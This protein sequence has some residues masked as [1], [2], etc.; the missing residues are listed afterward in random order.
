LFHSL[1]TSREY[2]DSSTHFNLGETRDFAP[3]QL[4]ARDNGDKLVSALL[5]S[6][7]FN[8]DHMVH[9]RSFTPSVL[10]YLAHT[11]GFR[12]VSPDQLAA[13]IMLTISLPPATSAAT[14]SFRLAAGSAT[15]SR[16]SPKVSSAR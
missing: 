3:D 7:D 6:R 8:T 16:D 5:T 12:D 1:L 15:S 4:D 2:D 14:M 13:A 11:F 10:R 9:D